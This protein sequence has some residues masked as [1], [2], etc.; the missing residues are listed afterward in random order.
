MPPAVL[1]LPLLLSSSLLLHHAAVDAECEP[2]ACG[3]LTIQY[4]FWLGAPGRPTPEPSCG[5]PA[6][7]LCG[8]PAFELWCIGGN[9]TAAM[10]GSPIHVHSIDYATSSFLVV[11]NRIAAGTDGA[12]LADF[13]VSS[14]LA[15]SP[16]KI[17]PSNR[18]LCF[19]YNCNGTEPRG[20]EYA[21]ATAG[22]SRPI[23]A[24]LGGSFVR[25]TPPAIPTGNC[26]YTYLP[27]LGSEAGVSTAAD[28]TRL[29]QAG[30]LLDWAGAG[31]GIGDCPACAASGGQCRY[32]G[33]TAALACLCPGGKLRGPTCAGEFPRR[34]L[35]LYS[36]VPIRRG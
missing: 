21:N 12:C 20:R 33:A 16:F 29:L 26:T 7:Q 22:C 2:A 25:D 34:H 24:Y 32:R 13:N 8:H 1:I 31:I 11:H 27:V 5:H 28:Y 18:A 30:F 3:N 15:L 23:V 6:L 4:P 14:S 10:S 9:T 35:P 36:T 19:L 17:S